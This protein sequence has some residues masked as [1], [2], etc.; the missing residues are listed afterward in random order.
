[1]QGL[2]LGGYLAIQPLIWANYFGRRYLGSIRGTFA[3]FQMVVAASAPWL[4]AAGGEA[5]GTYRYIFMVLLAFWVIN[6]GFMYM[7]R[8]LRVPEATEPATASA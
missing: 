6:L 3:P 2:V 4:L 1:M 7:A 5:F 8:P